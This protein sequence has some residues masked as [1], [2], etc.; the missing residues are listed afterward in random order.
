VDVQTPITDALLA[1]QR[2]SPTTVFPFDRA[3][4]LAFLA[5]LLLFSLPPLPG[6]QP[7]PLTCPKLRILVPVLSFALRARQYE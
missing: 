2:V 7:P 4:L 3:H 5:F 6:A 1:T